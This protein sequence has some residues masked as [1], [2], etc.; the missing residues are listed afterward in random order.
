LY[1]IAR[2]VTTKQSHLTT[3]GKNL[4]QKNLKPSINVMIIEDDDNYRNSLQEMINSGEGMVCKYACES[5]E[6]ALDTLKKDFVPEIVLLDIK[7]PGISGIEGIH[8]IK[9]IT[10][11]T[12]III[13]TVF[14]DDEKVFNAVCQGASGYLLKSTPGG[15]IKHAIR[16]VHC[17]GA[18]MSPSIAAKV[19]NMFARYSQPKQEYGLTTR[20]KEILQ[21]LVDGLSKK[22]IADKLCVSFYTIDTHLKNIYSKLHVHSQ[23]DVIS[24]TMKEHLI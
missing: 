22:H 2:S 7:L 4:N 14:D 24:K 21:L 18:A 9:A 12:P 8:K 17:G 10:P 19:L 20:E 11:A 1:V 5:C 3:A 15:K 13:L 23:I 6:A 16:D